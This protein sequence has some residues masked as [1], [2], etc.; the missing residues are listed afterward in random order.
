[1]AVLFGLPCVGVRTWDFALASDAAHE[2]FVF[3][4]KLLQRGDS[5]EAAAEFD[6]YLRDYPAG[7]KRT[8][9]AYYRAL[10]HREA[11]DPA[12]AAR[13]L[14]GVEPT[15]GALVPAYAVSLLRGQALVDTGAFGDALRTLGQIEVSTLEP[16]LALSV[17]YLRGQAARSAGDAG[18]A[19]QELSAAADLAEAQGHALQGPVLV[20][21]AEAQRSRG[22]LDAAAAALKRALPVDQPAVGDRSVGGEAWLAQAARLAGDVA[23]ERGEMD[24]AVRAYRRVIDGFPGSEH[25]GPAVVGTLWALYAAERDLEVI[26]TFDRLAETLPLQDRV[27][28]HYLAGSSEQRRGNHEAVV[29]LL[30][31]VA[32][33]N[34]AL[35]LEERVLYRLA[36]SRHALGQDERVLTAVARLNELFPASSLAADAAFLAASS[37]A[38]LGDAAAGVAA[39][40]RFVE[41][42]PD[43]PQGAATFLRALR[44]RAG[45]F[46][47]QGRLDAAIAD[48]ERYLQAVR[49]A[50]WN[51]DEAAQVTVAW[52]YGDVLQ[53]AGRP[54][55]AT[56]QYV[57]VVTLLERRR[58]EGKPL[59]DLEPEAY[60]RAGAAFAVAGEDASALRSFDTLLERFPLDALADQAALKRGAVLRRLGRNAEALTAWIDAA[61]R[62][63]LAASQRA[64]ALRAAA[65]VYRSADRDDDAAVTLNRALAIAGPESLVDDELLW[66]AERRLDVA[67][68]A[69]DD[70]D[71]VDSL[72]V[73][74][75]LSEA[76]RLLSTLD[77]ASRRPT[78]A[79]RSHRL[80]LGGRLALR[81]GQLDRA[82]E[83]FG[84]VL[85][86][87]EGFDLDAQLGLAE[88]AEARGDL[89]AARSEYDALT[90]A[91]ETSVAARAM[92]RLG[93]VEAQRAASLLR[94][95]RDRE[96][97]DAQAAA[98]RAWKRLALLYLDAEAL[99]P[100]P[101]LALLA[102]GELAEA[103]GESAVAA[104]EYGELIDAF[105]ESPFGRYAAAVVAGRFE[106]RA[107]DASA[108]LRGLLESDD[109][110]L[111]EPAL[112]S[113]ARALREA[114]EDRP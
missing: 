59:A 5:V 72:A 93:H 105:P 54:A 90:R 46:A 25:Y 110:E 113:R 80:Y 15:S 84:R 26:E 77:D 13:L 55:D 51:V 49:E 104:R 67:G 87:S 40:S 34:G 23:Y 57:D 44:Q 58:A 41:A 99:Q 75:A 8:D 63:N 53:R 74:S 98:R 88:V 33:G 29:A 7:G 12:A 70:A 38:R 106:G 100:T 68:A 42:G 11:G 14:S 6:R 85:A 71:A 83:H 103:M 73:Q 31:P 17:R 3:A 107:D 19:A 66:L 69:A 32:R 21:L 24:A 112:R 101:Q 82:T 76:E 86:L 30:E 27:A 18:L 52:A 9:A 97:I 89:D 35:P 20:A 10:L 47:S 78:T 79:Q 95:G 45:L 50:S 43:G 64:L 81:R 60:F 28:A 2:Q 56:R 62:E 37:R 36:V 94:Q 102:L 92:L 96:A 4:Y 114:L 1:M 48:Y 61:G 65:G 22:D 109:A 39:L 16:G 111:L 108:I 91:E